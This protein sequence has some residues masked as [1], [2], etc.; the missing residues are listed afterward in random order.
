MGTSPRTGRAEVSEAISSRNDFINEMINETFETKK[1]K[2]PVKVKV[3][4]AKDVLLWSQL[5][6]RNKSRQDQPSNSLPSPYAVA[7]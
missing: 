6:S 2:D 7:S 4:D 1:S 3:Y 5:N